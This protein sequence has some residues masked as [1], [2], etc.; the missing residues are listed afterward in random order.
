MIFGIAALFLLIGLG[1]V[2]ASMKQLYR[3]KELLGWPEVQAR[4]IERDVRSTGRP[5]GGPP[6]FR[7]EASLRFQELQTE[8]ESMSIFPESPI[9]DERTIEKWMNRF[10]DEVPVRKNPSN[11]GE[12][13]LLHGKP[14]LIY[15]M[16][17]VGALA[18]IIGLSIVIIALFA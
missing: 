11:P 5:G 14:T 12:L 3:R 13:V 2:I 16:L 17:T 15:A 10:P 4:I 1:A 9:S 8:V 6:A 7:K 18:L